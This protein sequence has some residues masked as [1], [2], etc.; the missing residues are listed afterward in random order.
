MLGFLRR[1]PAMVA[2]LCQRQLG[3]H[4]DNDM[5]RAAGSPPAKARVSRKDAMMRPATLGDAAERD[6]VNASSASREL[7]HPKP[8]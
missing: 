1:S 4:S 8:W 6:H 7:D 3:Q 5:R 2:S